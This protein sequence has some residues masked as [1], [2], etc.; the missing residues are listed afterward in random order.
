M[1]IPESN[2]N[3]Y[4]IKYDLLD[5]DT[6]AFFEVTFKVT[7]D[8][9][10]S[11]YTPKTV[12]GDYGKG[13]SPG[14]E[15]YIHWASR[16]DL[17]KQLSAEA[18]FEMASRR[19]GSNEIGSLNVIGLPTEARVYLDKKDLGFSPIRFRE[20]PTGEYQLRILKDE[21]EEYAKIII[22]EGRKTNEIIYSLKPT[23]GTLNIEG[24]PGDASVFING[25]PVGNT[26]I[27]NRRIKAGYYE[28]KIRK[29]KFEEY[30]TNTE[31]TPGILTSLTYDL[32]VINYS[33]LSIRGTPEQSIVFLDDKELGRA[34]L[35][36][37]RIPLGMHTLTVKNPGHK[38]YMTTFSAEPDNTN[39]MTYELIKRSPWYRQKKYQV[40]LGGVG[41]AGAGYFLQPGKEETPVLP[42]IGPG[43]DLPD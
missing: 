6:N 3:G 19:L 43:P 27:Q 33:F 17:N 5:N 14:K 32:K 28:V 16:A 9:G 39:E 23:F 40:L 20:I 11:Y 41:L 15:K 31:I 21:Y 2:N 10:S 4:E 1:I 30:T 22:I 42:P 12:T 18:R 34:P 8:G 36:L 35:E 25:Q 13:I 38:D 7:E 29:D 37:V 24:Y 26:P